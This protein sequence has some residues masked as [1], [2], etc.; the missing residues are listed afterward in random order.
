MALYSAGMC[1]EKLPAIYQAPALY[2]KAA[3][4][5]GSSFCQTISPA[6]YRTPALYDPHYI[7]PPTVVP[8]LRL[9]HTDTPSTRYPV[10]NKH[11]RPLTDTTASSQNSPKGQQADCSSTER[12]SKFHIVRNI[13]ASWCLLCVR[14]LHIHPFFPPIGIQQTQQCPSYRI[15]IT[16]RTQQRYRL[17]QATRRKITPQANVRAVCCFFKFRP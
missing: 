4:I 12:V 15:F 14:V 1:H 13:N 7:G 11:G 3:T 17:G 10:N 16:L 2:K 8:W 9:S 6:Q 5:Q